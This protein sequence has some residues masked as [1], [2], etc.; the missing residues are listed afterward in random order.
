MSS[1]DS[2]AHAASFDRPVD[3]AFMSQDSWLAFH[4]EVYDAVAELG[5]TVASIDPGGRQR[6]RT[7]EHDQAVCPGPGDGRGRRAR[8][9]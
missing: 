9:R 5:L 8:F 1:N 7:G 3:F 2:S 6:S 4:C